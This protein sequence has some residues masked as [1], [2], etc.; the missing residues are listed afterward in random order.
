MQQTAQSCLLICIFNNFF[1]NVSKTLWTL[2]IMT[3]KGQ[4]S[5][6]YWIS[7]PAEQLLGSKGFSCTS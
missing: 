5:N 6:I 4:V 7:W 1:L 3:S 2:C